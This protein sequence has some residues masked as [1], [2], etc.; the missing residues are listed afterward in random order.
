MKFSDLE[1]DLYPSA[2]AATGLG[3]DLR[4]TEAGIKVEMGMDYQDWLRKTCELS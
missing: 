3:Q 1:L 4:L 2:E